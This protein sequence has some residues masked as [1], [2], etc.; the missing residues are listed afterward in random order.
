M[1][2]S[3]VRRS[4]TAAPLQARRSCDA[5]ER[6]YDHGSMDDGRVWRRVGPLSGILALVFSLGGFAL[7]AAAGLAVSPGSSTGDIA[8]KLRDGNESLALAGVYVDTIGSLFFLVFA[9]YLF[10]QFSGGGPFTEWLA[11]VALIAAVATVVAG[12][13]D[14][15]AYHAVFT[16]ADEGIDAE[17]A[18]GLYD[19]AS[20][21]F[22]LF[23]IFAGL[24]ALAASLAALQTAVFR[25]WLAW[26][27]IVIGV[28][29]I[30]T[31]AERE[32]AQ[33]AFPLFG[34]WIV[35]MSVALLRRPAK[36]WSSAA[37][38]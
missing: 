27:G 34:L 30:A 15:A 1:I 31:G 9:A 2:G 20:G 10:A 33:L 22:M 4:V 35:A 7:I 17:V 28:I 3:C 21:F 16:R 18:A 19:L 26:A 29:G 24:F 11:T 6:S 12:M 8:E 25:R 32:T 37:A 13:G 23:G 36:M 5:T 14:K 38:D